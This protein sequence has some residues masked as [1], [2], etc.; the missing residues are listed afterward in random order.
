MWRQVSRRA[1]RQLLFPP[2]LFVYAAICDH[3][4]NLRLCS[5]EFWLWDSCFLYAVTLLDGPIHANRFADSNQAIRVNCLRVPELNPH[6]FANYV[7]DQGFPKGGFCEGGKIS[8][9]GVVRAPVAIINFASNPCEN[10]W[11]YIGFNK[12]AP[13]KKTQD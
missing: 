10:L 4:G 7:L 2:P 6:F 5:Y 3:S 1:P 13:H 8:I 9:I 11:V 12:E